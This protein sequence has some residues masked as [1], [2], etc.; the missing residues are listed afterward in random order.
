MFFF[1]FDFPVRIDF[2]ISIIFPFR[3]F[4]LH[5]KLRFHWLGQ[6]VYAI[7]C[8]ATSAHECASERTVRGSRRGPELMQIHT[9][10]E[11]TSVIK[12]VPPKSSRNEPRRPNLPFASKPGSLPFLFPEELADAG[13][14]RKKR[15]MFPLM[16]NDVHEHL[17]RHV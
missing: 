2:L 8:C 9:Q 7:P 17:S 4:L 11:H 12:S 1:L 13:I 6:L 5:I 16:V 14:L 10:T 15:Q 3:I